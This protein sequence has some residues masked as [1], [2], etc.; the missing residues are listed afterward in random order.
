MDRTDELR[1]RIRRQT[2]A[3]RALLADG[4]EGEHAVTHLRAI[5]RLEAEL[6]QIEGGSD[7]RE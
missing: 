1:Q 2:A 5:R 6:A 7:A 4:T 3:Y